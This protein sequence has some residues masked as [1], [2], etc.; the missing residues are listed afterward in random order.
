MLL[1]EQA[2]PYKFSYPVK[3]AIAALLLVR[4]TG[5]CDVGKVNN[6]AEILATRNVLQALASSTFLVTK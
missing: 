6:S 3:C 4:L 5:S 2:A 1:T